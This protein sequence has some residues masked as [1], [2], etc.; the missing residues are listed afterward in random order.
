[1][2]QNDLKSLEATPFSKILIA[3]RGEIALRIMRTAHELGYATVAVYSNADAF[4][5]HVKFANE[6]VCLGGS[7]PK[8]SYLNIEAI[9]AA[10]RLTHADAI[11]PGYGFLAENPQLARACLAA[12]IVFIGPSAEA[13]DAMG[14]KANAKE[15]MRKIGVPCIPGFEGHDQSLERLMAE[16]EKIGYPVM[17][18][19]CNGGG[20]RGMRLVNH[21]QDFQAALT[22]AKAE[23]LSAFGSEKVLLEKALVDPRHIEI[24]ILADRFGNVIHLGERDC[25]VQRRHQKI[26]EEAPSPAVTTALREAMGATAIAAVKAIAYEGAGTLEFLLDADGHYYFM[27]M[28]T[29]LQVEHP[30]TEAITGLDLVAL[31]L[32][33][34]AGQRLPIHQSDI[35]FEGH[36]IEVRL[37][38]EDVENNFAPQSGQVHVWKAPTGLRTEH[39]LSCGSEISPYYDSMLAKVI[40]HG[41]DRETAIAKL[42]QGLGELNAFGIATN[43]TFLG[44]VLAHP[45]FK[46]GQAST[47]FIAKHGGE[48]NQLDSSATLSTSVVAVALLITNAGAS[49]PASPL[50]HPF[51]ILLNFKRDNQTVAANV[52]Q[53]SATRFDV[54]GELIEVI[55]KTAH[56]DRQS[57]SLTLIQ[58]GV[59]KRLSIARTGQLRDVLW[60]QHGSQ[61]HTV[62]DLSRTPLAPR[63][64]QTTDAVCRSST[65]GK[66]VAL[67]AKN[68]DVVEIGQAIA[69]IEAMKMEHFQVATMAGIVSELNLKLG[70][71]IKLKQQICRLT[72]RD[73]LT[74]EQA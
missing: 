43:Q 17:I 44:Q 29:R 28:N 6:A 23:S 10:A 42:V 15:Q 7:E 65:N 68:G 46:S 72:P 20:G 34:A 66:V 69:S 71:Q 40:S 4:N 51:P 67:H 33:I 60:I 39:A 25:S 26:V 70:E 31:Q 22:S 32:Q 61:I 64:N 9:I 45:V 47:S 24:Q 3:N 50:H 1:M 16:A 63:A 74:A 73:S 58:Q 18:K 41:V 2:K 52:T 5:P 21:N 62:V 56:A 12:G 35:R 36:A 27:E 59:Q 55:E 14:D 49:W 13:I 8:Q 38:A 57:H 19:A 37:C 30:V 48:V 53:Q 54:M 11:H